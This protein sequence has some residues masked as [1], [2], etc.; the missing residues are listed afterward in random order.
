MI[1]CL[2]IVACKSKSDNTP[3]VITVNFH[4]YTEKPISE[5]AKDFCSDK[6]YVV[7]HADEQNLM[8][9][10][11]THVVLYG[12]RI[13]AAD[14]YA[15]NLVVHDRNGHAIAKVGYR[16]RGSGEYANLSY[17]DV[18]NQGRIH[19]IDGNQDRL[20]IYDADYKFL[21]AKDLPFEVDIIK[22]MPDGG[23]LLGL[24][25]WDSSQYGGTRIVR[26]TS[27][28]T[29]VDKIGKYDKE[30]TD[31]NVWLSDYYF[32]EMPK[33]I[34]YHKS[35]DENVYL[36]DKNGEIIQQY[37]FDLGDDAVP[38]R[39][40][41]NLEPVIESEE[42]ALY[43]ALLNFA[44]VRDRYVFGSM[45]DK[46]LLKSYIY[47]IDQSVMYT[48]NEEEVDDF[49]N[50]LMINNDYLVT[51]FPYPNDESLPKDLPSEMRQ[52][53]IDGDLLICLYKL[54]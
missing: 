45:Y 33:G 11:I 53:V 3:E 2:L 54:K 19:L 46:G 14:S 16:G 36:L 8:L 13:Y 4:S 42:I 25:S 49:G 18:D 50:I 27:D 12:D 51:L 22:C 7:L 10:N 6:H 43:R 52:Q 24:S 26:T 37:F 23:Y 1:C 9:K 34:F 17:F 15:R 44:V 39:L 38:V 28:L 41:K 29:V 48:K 20:M 40:R 5:I 30:L 47:D 21:E 32:I 31:D 35:L